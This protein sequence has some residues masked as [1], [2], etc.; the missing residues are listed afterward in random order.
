MLIIDDMTAEDISG[1]CLVEE[2]CFTQPWSYNAFLSEL[3]N[4]TAVTLIAIDEKEVVGFVNARFLLGEGSINNIAV[5]ARE[6]RRHVGDSLMK[7]LLSRASSTGILTLTLEVRASN[8]G[9]ISFYRSYGFTEVGRRKSF[10]E[11]PLEDALLMTLT[12]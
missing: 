5:T 10:Y 12:L 3:Q 8:K 6:R 2:E 1:V 9:A 4:D 11:Q 7:A